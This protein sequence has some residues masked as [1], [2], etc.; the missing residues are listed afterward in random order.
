[1]W[2]D[3]SSLMCSAVIKL[4]SY[5]YWL[6]KF[7]SKACQT[8]RVP[9]KSVEQPIIPIVQTPGRMSQT[10]AITVYLRAASV[11]IPNGASKETIEAV[12]ITLKAL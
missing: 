2:N 9:A 3:N 10:T 11:D 6:R 1:M 7:R 12:L 4:K 5:Y 8:E